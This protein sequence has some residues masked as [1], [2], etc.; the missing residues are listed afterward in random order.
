[1]FTGPRLLH[2]VVQAE[3]GHVC[4][5]PV[6]WSP[7]VF[8]KKVNQLKHIPWKLEKGRFAIWTLQLKSL[9]NRPLRSAFHMEHRAFL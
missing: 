9:S 8:T 1:M 3:S 5:T 4:Q 7:F 6:I 2:I